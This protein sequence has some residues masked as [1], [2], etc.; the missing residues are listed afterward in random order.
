MY[1]G[2]AVAAPRELE[3]SRSTAAEIAASGR[4]GAT[5]VTVAEGWPAVVLARAV[6]GQESRPLVSP[7]TE[8]LDDDSTTFLIDTLEA[9][10][11]FWG[12]PKRAAR[13]LAVHPNTVRN[14]AARIVE[15]CPIDLEDPE[16]RLALRLEIARLRARD[17][18][19]G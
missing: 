9:M 16:Q 3:D 4:G 13:S 14:R 2:T 11:D 8:L 1:V 6:Q 10:I 17:G 7:L 5:V 19:E 18:R 15:L 12:E